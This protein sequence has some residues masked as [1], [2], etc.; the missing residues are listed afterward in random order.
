MNVRLMCI[1]IVF[2]TAC[3]SYNEID[4]AVIKKYDEYNNKDSVVIDFSKEMSFDWDSMYYFSGAYSLED[5]D[6][7]LG[8]NIHDWTDVGDRLVFSCHNRITRHYEW[9]MKADNPPCGVAFQ[10][11]N[12]NHFSLSKSQA[13]FF[14]TK[15]DQLY[16]LLPCDENE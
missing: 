9:P 14:I 10:I 16:I 3:N 5:I 8:R 11:G 2:L 4:H 12:R 15:K 7:T 6:R 1:V 13:K